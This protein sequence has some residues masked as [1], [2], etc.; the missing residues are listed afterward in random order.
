MK[1]EEGYNKIINEVETESAIK[2][3]NAPS[4]PLYSAWHIINLSPFL[5]ITFLNLKINSN[6]LLIQQQ[7]ARQ[8]RF[9]WIWGRG[10]NKE[11]NKL[12]AKVRIRS[13]SENE[14][15]LHPTLG[16]DTKLTTHDLE[17]KTKKT[18]EGMK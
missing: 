9:A 13:K 8:S 18:E 4:H 10:E 2:K 1:S 11:E 15:D 7:Q 14:I 5:F 12:D 3:V 17:K 6:L 16:I